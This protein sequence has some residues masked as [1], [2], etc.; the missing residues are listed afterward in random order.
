MDKTFKE[1]LIK[2]LKKENLKK[3]EIDGLLRIA[4]RLSDFSHVK[5][6]DNVKKDFL[7]KLNISN[8]D[9]R[10]YSSI[11]F[12]FAL[13]LL[14]LFVVSSTSLAYAQNSQPGELLYPLKRLSEKAIVNIKPDF[15]K[16]ILKRREEEIK[17]L[18]EK[19]EDS[20]T[21]NEAKEEYKKELESSEEKIKEKEKKDLNKNKEIKR[22]NEEERKDNYDKSEEEYKKEEKEKNGYNN[23]NDEGKD[24]ESQYSEEND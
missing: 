12:P 13:A 18:I 2:E 8:S 10:N 20:E 17:D 11:Y 6:S 16:E 5:R 7:K 22:D 14:I 19:K 21:I 15:K 3:E 1:N 24:R 4:T 23:D 9:N